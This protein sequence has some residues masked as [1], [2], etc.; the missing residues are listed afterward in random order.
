MS[1]VPLTEP[2]LLLAYKPNQFFNKLD[3]VSEYKKK[4]LQMA[5][6]R[7]K[8]RGLIEES[9]GKIKLSLEARQ[10]ITPYVAKKI[11][12]GCLMVIFDIPNEIE[13]KRN[14]LRLVLRTLKFEQAQKSVWIS[15]LD[16]RVVLAE[17]IRD[18]GLNDYVKIYE[19][20][21]LKI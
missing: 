21:I 17:T 19:S 13:H 7:A 10:Q 4:N 2:N 14:K 6:A 15:K 20:A 3:K 16:S 8:K 18:L 9:N 12:N 5:Y 11:D 1:F